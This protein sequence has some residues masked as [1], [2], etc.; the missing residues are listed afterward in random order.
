MRFIVITL[1][2]ILT[3][4]ISF[5]LLIQITKSKRFGVEKWTWT[6]ISLIF[7]ISLVF[8][9]GIALWD[10]NTFEYEARAIP[11][12]SSGLVLLGTFDL[13]FYWD[14]T[15]IQPVENIDWGTLKAGATGDVTLY[16]KNPNPV[17][18]YLFAAWDETTWDPLGAEQYF[19][20]N[21]DQPSDRILKAGYAQRVNMHLQVHPDIIGVKAFSFD[22]IINVDDEPY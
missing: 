21:W 19:T 3:G 2:V 4:Y 5:L 15:Q 17:D 1:T 20:F 8:G 7:G 10:Y 18:V 6:L 13:Q 9:A 12:S 22:I 14:V 11:I 16:V